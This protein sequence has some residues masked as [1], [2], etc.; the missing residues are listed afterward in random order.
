MKKFLSKIM[1]S[2]VAVLSAAGFTSCNNADDDPRVITPQ[3]TAQEQAQEQQQ[4][5]QQVLGYGAAVSE[6]VL[7]M[8]DVTVTLHSGD[9]TK[10]VE[11]TKADGKVITENAEGNS[12]TCYKYV[13]T[14]IDGQNGISSTEVK[15][16][17]K[18]D[19]K[20][21]IA[22]YPQDK[23]VYEMYGSDR[24]YASLDA[25]GKLVNDPK[26]LMHFNKFLPSNMMQVTH[27][28]KLVYEVQAEAMGY[29]YLTR[30]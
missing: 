29:F 22:S 20:T 5:Y 3:P 7:D 19:I 28:G 18:A 30:K 24:I 15:V 9:K 25:N 13:F 26:V 14:G 23:E 16:T 6:S 4:K 1:F 17:P 12:I 11:L 10:V 27:D 8:Y 2:A 21:T